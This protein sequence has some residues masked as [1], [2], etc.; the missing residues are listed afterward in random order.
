MPILHVN[1]TEKRSTDSKREFID[2]CV[3]IIAEE[4]GCNDGA[5]KVF[6][7]EHDPEN[8][9]NEKPVVFL[10]WM[11]VPE[12]RTQEVKDRIASRITDEVNKLTDVPKEDV[13]ILINDYPPR[14]IAVGG[15]CRS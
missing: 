10:N 8:A 9:R 4:S 2:N 7:E 14:H 15:K 6:L 12:K 13:I 3:K 11:E 1:Y 5:I